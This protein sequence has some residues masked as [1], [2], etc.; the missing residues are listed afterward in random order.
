MA[1]YRHQGYNMEDH[2]EGHMSFEMDELRR[3][4]QELQQRLKQYENQGRGARHY[5]SESDDENPFHCAHSHT[6]GGST[7]PHPC[8][9]EK[10]TTRF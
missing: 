5:D 2:D 10:F 8:F 1:G 9:F 7:P 6:S 3:Q 4:L